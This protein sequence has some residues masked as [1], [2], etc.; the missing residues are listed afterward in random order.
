MRQQLLQAVMATVCAL[1]VVLAF[2]ACQTMPQGEPVAS[3]AGPTDEGESPGDTQYAVNLRCFSAEDASSIASSIQEFAGYK[4]QDLVK[5][6]TFHVIHADDQTSTSIEVREYNYVTSA[7]ASDLK[8]SFDGL[9]KDSKTVSVSFAEGEF[10]IDQMVAYEHTVIVFGKDGQATEQIKL[11]H[12][13]CEQFLDS[14]EWL[15]S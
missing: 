4:G 6:E 9:F 2:T 8:A 10:T 13:P 12:T 15:A 3:H 11:I 14:Q 5:S 1:T 7:V